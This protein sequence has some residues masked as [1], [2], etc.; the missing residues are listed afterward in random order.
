MSKSTSDDNVVIAS[1]IETFRWQKDLAERAIV[2]LDDEQLHKPL[3]PETNSI[4][5]IMKHMAGNMC[6]RWTDFL[7]SDGEKP[8][9][10]RD[11]EFVDD[12]GSREELQGLWEEGWTCVF[13]AV[14][15]LSDQD[16]EKIVQIRGKPHSVIRA[17][18]RAIDH[19]GY[20]VGQIVQIAR[21]RAQ[22]DW[23]TLSI[24]RGESEAYNQRLWQT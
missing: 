3:D 10:H 2:Q 23:T 4:A 13:D 15:Q 7:T 8:C 6:S 1:A 18:D 5:V 17:I 19:Y 16:L 22:H 24:P 20:H 11:D 12:I 14:S 9:R 21:I